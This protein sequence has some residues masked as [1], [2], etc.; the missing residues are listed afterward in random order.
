MNDGAAD[1]S[2]GSPGEEGAFLARHP[3]VEWVDAI[4]P[5]LCGV[6]RGKRLPR[7]H[8]GK[9]FGEGMLIPGSVFILDVSGESTDAC[10]RGF[11][12]GDP[13]YA[14]RAVPGSLRL[15]PWSREPRAQALCT[16]YEPGGRPYGFD[17]RNLLAG[18]AARF[19]ELGLTP[20][21]ALELEFYLID[22]LRRPDGAPR[23]PRSPVTGEAERETQVYS[24]G[25][26]DTYSDFLT[27][28]GRCC[29]EQGIPAGPVTA[30]YA[31]GQ[32][33]VN[34]NHVADS[35]AA[36]DAAVLLTRAVKGV[37]RRQGFDATFMARPYPDHSGNG[38]HIH[39]S[40]VDGDG[41]NRFDDGGPLG[42]PMLRHAVGGIL[43]T[44]AE[45]MAILAPNRNSY[46]RFQPNRYVPT[47]PT[48]GVNNRSVAVRVPAGE[49][50][51][52]RVEHR[53]AGA[54]ANPYL[55][56]AVA[57]AAMHHGMVNQIDPGPPSEGN[58]GAVLSPDLPFNWRAAL[59][60]LRDAKVLPGY[61]GA[62][63]CEL[64]RQTKE[65]ELAKFEADV[66]PL[67]YQWYL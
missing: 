61:L 48:W 31:P 67:E 30:E 46:R 26:L 27:E 50:K 65:F 20:V 25:A 35:L 14:A 3:E 52:R 15:V 64:Y 33:E 5:D 21:V 42:G 16:L 1:E 38:L 18:V 6:M 62:E 19:G 29:A 44:M 53:I 55:A 13:D 51:S 66:P 41:A 10:G 24:L 2:A 37:A 63:Y 4:L 12:D 8:L 34:L 36:A 32:F 40:L 60:R 45:A 59:E 22:R 11:S 54:D 47:A 58:V 17:P 39:V 9:L 57:L 28:V 43:A 49:G 23:P 56:T 7:E